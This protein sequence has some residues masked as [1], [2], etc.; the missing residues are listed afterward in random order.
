MVA[1]VVDRGGLTRLNG[2]MSTGT[3]PTEDAQRVAMEGLA[4]C[5]DE[6]SFDSGDPEPGDRGPGGGG[7][8]FLTDLADTLRAAGLTVNEHDGWQR[9]HR[10]S[11]GYNGGPVGII[12]HHT[13]SP[14][15]WDGQRDVDFIAVGCDV[16]PM[17]NLYLDR[18]GQWWV[19][20]AGA[21]NTN[22]KGGPW[23]PLPLDSANSRVIGIEAGN[24][25]VGEAWPE[26]MQ[27]AYVAGVAALASHYGVDTGNILAHHEWAPA[28]K[29]D[30]AGPSR[31]GAINGAKSWNM[32]I[33]RAAVAAKRGN[34]SPPPSTR[35]VQQK[36]S[37]NGATY[38]VQ[39]GDAWWSIAKKAMGDPATNWPVLAE[40]NGGASRVLH[41]GDVLTVPGG[42]GAG[43][44]PAAGPGVGGDGS[45]PPY[46]GD[47]E[48]G[49]TGPVVTA[50]QEA[51]IA[52]GVISDTQANHDGAYGEG[53]EKAVRKLQ[54]SWG[55]SDADGKAG[56]HTWRKL[57]GGA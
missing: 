42:S 6:D 49:Q 25:G 20:A 33:F 26:V 56:S 8:R 35:I 3:D 45:I 46:P 28:R 1:V 57:F 14:A 23:G 29:V 24:D 52:R 15:S 38:V 51:L 21:S 17:A 13:A 34:P 10:S 55:W 36:V 39:P 5:R 37:T 50:W 12:V 30:P 32:D 47:A 54:E 41:P 7:G 31:F 27:D 44:G 48:R 2:A 4:D 40:A 16:A 11:G 18:K 19:L 9:R 43:P 22:G 53:M